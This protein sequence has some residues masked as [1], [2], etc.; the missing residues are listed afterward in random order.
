MAEKLS[1]LIKG[2]LPLQFGTLYADAFKKKSI[3]IIDCSVASDLLQ[4][5]GNIESSV[6][7]IIQGKLHFENSPPFST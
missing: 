3:A 2:V 7:S 1:S 5:G 6:K 4:G